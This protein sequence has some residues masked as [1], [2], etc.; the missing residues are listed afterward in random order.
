MHRKEIVIIMVCTVLLVAYLLL[1]L[2][3]AAKPLTQILLSPVIF[4]GFILHLSSE[5][6]FLDVDTAGAAQTAARLFAFSVVLAWITIPAFI[7]SRVRSRATSVFKW[8]A[9]GIA[10][11]GVGFSLTWYVVL[12]LM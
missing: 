8:C 4:L 5:I 11:A 2:A 1:D 12:R 3:N 7:H 6:R 10:G 9:R